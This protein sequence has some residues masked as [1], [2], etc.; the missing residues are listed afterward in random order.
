MS[1]GSDAASIMTGRVGGVSTLLKKGNPFLINIH[2]MAHCL[3]LCTSHAANNVENMERYR[4]LLTDLHYY[5]SKSA[6]RAAGLKAIQEVLQSP[7]LKMKEMHAVRWFAF[8]NALETVYR[9]WDV[10]VTYFAIQK[11][12]QRQQVFSRS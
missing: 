4:Q 12:M 7:Q 8:Y 5:C 11:K 10:L 3:A 1:F 6:K 2:C 9:S